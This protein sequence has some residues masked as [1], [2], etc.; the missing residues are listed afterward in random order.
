M[1]PANDI[2]LQNTQRVTGIPSWQYDRQ[3]ECYK[4]DLSA[5][6]I[7]FTV[8]KSHCDVINYYFAEKADSRPTFTSPQPGQKGALVSMTSPIIAGE[9]AEYSPN[10]PLLT[11]ASI[12][13]RIRNNQT[14]DSRTV[15]ITTGT[16][17]PIPVS[18]PME[19]PWGGLIRERLRVSGLCP[20]SAELFSPEHIGLELTLTKEAAS[21][22]AFMKFLS[23]FQA[24]REI[25]AFIKDKIQ[26]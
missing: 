24:A 11:A 13:G 8:L 12:V 20:D 14:E 16:L 5:A 1:Q 4:L 21:D 3:I 23:E 15:E 22:P 17:T 25:F 7:P 6:R 19:A 10:V 9:R 26:K 2:A 18:G